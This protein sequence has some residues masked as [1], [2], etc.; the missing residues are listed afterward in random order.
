MNNNSMQLAFEIKSESS[1][2]KTENDDIP[3]KNTSSKPTPSQTVGTSSYVPSQKN[4][5]KIN[6][7]ITSVYPT[8]PSICKDDKENSQRINPNA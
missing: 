2:G 8:I 4:T 5:G 6:S 1:K 7:H 3:V